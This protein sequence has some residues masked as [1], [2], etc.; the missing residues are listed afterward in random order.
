M[1]NLPVLS[2]CLADFEKN[3]LMV[4][5]IWI[6]GGRQVRNNI[7][8]IQTERSETEFGFCHNKL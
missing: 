1:K 7:S 5:H 2:L 3:V 4:L 6:L 8:F